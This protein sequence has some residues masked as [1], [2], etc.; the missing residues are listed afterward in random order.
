MKK[1]RPAL[2]A[3]EMGHPALG[4]HSSRAAPKAQFEGEGFVKGLATEVFEE[5]TFWLTM[6]WLTEMEVHLPRRS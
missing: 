6:T 3:Q 2:A 5:V 4:L 1:P